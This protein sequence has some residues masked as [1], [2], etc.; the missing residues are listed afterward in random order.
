MEITI[1]LFHILLLKMYLLPNSLD[2]CISL[3]YINKNQERKKNNK[4]K[5][6]TLNNNNKKPHIE[7]QMWINFSS[8]KSEEKIN[9]IKYLAN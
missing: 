7:F 6:N 3:K 5:K 4:T 1:Q 2:K 8:N 9:K